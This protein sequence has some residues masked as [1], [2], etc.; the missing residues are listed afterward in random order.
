M[1]LNVTARRPPWRLGGDRLGA[2]RRVESRPQMSRDYRLRR[3]AHLSSTACRIVHPCTRR[4]KPN[5]CPDDAARFPETPAKPSF[6]FSRDRCAQAR[7]D[8]EARATLE[9]RPGPLVGNP[10]R[11]A[12][13]G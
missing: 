8:K 6:G 13:W 2:D 9:T 4:R 11:I 3:V 7:E 1:F 10:V 12:P 5:G